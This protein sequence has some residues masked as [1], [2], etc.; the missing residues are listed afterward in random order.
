MAE[1]YARIPAHAV[2][3]RELSAADWRVLAAIALHADGH[4]RAYPGMTTIATLAGIRRNDVPR[5]I[6]RLEQHGILRRELRAHSSGSPDTNLYVLAF[7]AGDRS[8]MGV[9]N[10]ADRGVSATLRTRV[11]RSRHEGVRNAADQNRPIEQYT[12]DLHPPVARSARLRADGPRIKKE[13]ATNEFDTFW[14][15]YPHRG[16]FSDPKKSAWT[17]FAAAVGRGVNPSVII[18]GAQRYRDHVE[19]DGV[20]PRFVAQAAT[21]LNQERWALLYEPEPARLQVGMN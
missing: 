11:R 21:W 9:R 20:E 6:R 3:C 10:P 17:K 1:R 16:S 5:S 8:A 15:L 4:G 18:A 13:A 14:Q 7:A 12:I 19:R 2:G